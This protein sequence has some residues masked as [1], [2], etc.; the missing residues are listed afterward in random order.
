MKPKIIVLLLSMPYIQYLIH[1]E[2]KNIIVTQKLFN[3]LNAKDW[4]QSN[5]KK[6]KAIKIRKAKK[7]TVLNAMLSAIRLVKSVMGKVHITSDT[8]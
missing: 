1:S 4:E 8:V 6:A 7:L 3:A 5:V 2:P